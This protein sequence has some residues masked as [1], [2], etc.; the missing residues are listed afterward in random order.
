MI[1]GRAFGWQR[2]CGLGGLDGWVRDPVGW[3]EVRRERRRW[4][5]GRRRAVASQDVTVSLSSSLSPRPS[6]QLHFCSLTHLLSLLCHSAHSHLQAHARS[7][8]SSSCRWPP[9][10]IGGQAAAPTRCVVHG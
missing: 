5:G 4:R 2:A 7:L 3:R 1:L 9:S 8:L 10:S 6:L